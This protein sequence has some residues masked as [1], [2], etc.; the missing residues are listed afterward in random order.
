VASNE[1]KRLFLDFTT[2]IREEAEAER[3]MKESEDEE[4]SIVK[5]EDDEDEDE[6]EDVEEVTDSSSDDGM[7]SDE[8]AMWAAYSADDYDNND[9]EDRDIE[10]A[11]GLGSYS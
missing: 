2:D 6:D 4:N 10:D 9:D 5:D 11:L 1:S 7:V 3:R 8:E